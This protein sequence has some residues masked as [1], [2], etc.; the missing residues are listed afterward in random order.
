MGADCTD[1][2]GHGE[3]SS[4][5]GFGQPAVRHAALWVLRSG[6]R[7][8]DLSQRYGKFKSVHK[9]FTSWAKAGWK[10]AFKALSRDRD[11]EYLM[12]AS[13]IVRAHGQAANAR[14]DG[15]KTKLWPLRG[16]LSSKWHV[17]VGGLRAA[18][19][20]RKPPAPLS[21]LPGRMFL[22]ETL[23]KG[24]QESA[25]GGSARA[26]GPPRGR[27]RLDAWIILCRR[28]GRQVAVV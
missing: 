2:A 8:S 11:S 18:R 28:T 21:L 4:S 6:A 14:N 27:L 1:A 23:L 16:G 24:G 13:A 7:R 26:A 10:R 17:A 3:R 25:A 22:F 12:I 19:R 20:I 5:H 15:S 9:R